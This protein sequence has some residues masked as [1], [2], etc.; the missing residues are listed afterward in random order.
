[1]NRLVPWNM[2][3]LLHST[4]E[5]ELEGRCVPGSRKEFFF[6]ELEWE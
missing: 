5:L 6:E 2:Q 4:L 3:R 1:M